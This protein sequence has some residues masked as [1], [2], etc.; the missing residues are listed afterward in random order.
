[1][2]SC[3]CVIEGSH[4]VHFDGRL[5]YFSGGCILPSLHHWISRLCQKSAR[6]VDLARQF[7]ATA[8]SPRAWK[9]KASNLLYVAD[10]LFRAYKAANDRDWARFDKELKRKQFQGHIM[11]GQELADHWDVITGFSVYLL[12]TGYAI[13]NLIKGIIYSKKPSMLEEDDKNLR[14][15]RSLVHHQLANLYVEA[16]LAI[17]KD[18]IDP[19][20]KEILDYLEEFITWRGRYNLP[21]NL[22]QAKNMKP[23]PSCI[24]RGGELIPDKINELI[25]HLMSEIDK[26]PDPPT[27]LAGNK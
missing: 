20:T 25:G 8:L 7:E 24:N 19:D 9:Y 13:E 22:Q 26:I 17:N 21:L 15:K 4:R 27:H 2:V 23:L 10:K 14:L 5:K 1:M 12:L 18:A 16:C 3:I 6:E 11:K